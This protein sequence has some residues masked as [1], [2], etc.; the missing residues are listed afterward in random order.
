MIYKTLTEEIYNGSLA[1]TIRIFGAY[2]MFYHSKSNLKTPYILVLFGLFSLV[3]PSLFGAGYI[4]PSGTVVYDNTPDQTIYKV[5]KVSPMPSSSHIITE[6][7]PMQTTRVIV[8]DR[9]VTYDSPVII[10]ERIIDRGPVY[11]VVDAA[12]T[13]LF[14]GLLYDAV[15]HGFYHYGPHGPHNRFDR[16]GR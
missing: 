6:D 12:G 3:A 13:V 4:L 16:Y 2:T 1:F 14:F 9:V 15:G 8:E 7:T 10:R 5:E 11:D